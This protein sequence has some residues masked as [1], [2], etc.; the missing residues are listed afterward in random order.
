M[1]AHPPHASGERDD[2]AEPPAGVDPAE[3]FAAPEAAGEPP[4][5]LVIRRRGR[6]VSTEPPEGYLGEPA[7]E[8]QQS[9]ENDEQLRRDLPPHWG[10]R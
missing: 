2:A 10:K 7:R 5:P 6:R 3:E 4:V 9:S 8:R 1:T